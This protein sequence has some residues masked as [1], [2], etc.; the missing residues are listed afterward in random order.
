[1]PFVLGG[2]AP[3]E[4]LWFLLREKLPP[5]LDDVLP[6]WQIVHWAGEIAVAYC[7]CAHADKPA[8]KYENS[9]KLKV[10]FAHLRMEAKGKKKRNFF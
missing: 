10:Q 8:A 7:A 4:R 6:W 1:M 2:E 9:Q 5:S 3:Q